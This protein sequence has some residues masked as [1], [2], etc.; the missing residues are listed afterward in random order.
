MCRLGFEM[1]GHWKKG[2]KLKPIVILNKLEEIMTITKD[3]KVSYSG[4][5][6]QGY[7][8]TLYSMFNFPDNFSIGRSQGLLNTAISTVA[9]EGKITEKKVEET[10]QVL[11]NKELECQEE[12]FTVL[13]S[14]SI[15]QP[16]S[17][18][19][20]SVRSSKV[21]FFDKKYPRKY[22]SRN[23]SDRY[24]DRV[25]LALELDQ[26][27]YYKVVV[28]TKA[29]EKHKAVS[30]CLENLDLLRAIW[31]LDANSTMEIFGSNWRPINKIRLG[32]IHTIHNENGQNIDPEIFWYE[33][34]FVETK[35]FETEEI[36]DKI[37]IKNTRTVLRR[38]KQSKYS[39]KIENALI[40]YVRAFDEKDHNVALLQIWGALE[41]LT[42]DEGS[43]KSKVPQRCAYLYDEY[44]YHKQTLESIKEYRNKSVHAGDQNDQARTYCYQLQSY[45]GQLVY[46][47]LKNFKDFNSLEEANSFLDLSANGDALK[48]QMFMTKK[49]LR[50]RQI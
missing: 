16:L 28:T 25:G 21:E 5:S 8:A 3:G 20:I 39:E 31:S 12:V 13:A 15:A 44:E 18:K 42:A 41:S 24:I 9:K 48:K 7:M 49:A 37:F 32:S 27:N 1:K 47:H 29:K 43:N 33:P 17:S 6:Y 11:I 50:F 45:F 22:K 34:N 46:F 30:Q 40:R 14:I 26:D 38:L 35:L 36:K 2:G 10:F 4:F 23:E 19:K